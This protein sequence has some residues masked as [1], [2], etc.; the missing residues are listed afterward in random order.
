MNRVKITEAKN[1]LFVVQKYL[2][3]KGKYEF[4]RW[5]PISFSGLLREVCNSLNSLI[6]DQFAG[7]FFAVNAKSIVK[8]NDYF[9]RGAYTQY[10]LLNDSNE[11][12][13]RTLLVYIL[14]LKFA[15]MLRQNKLFEAPLNENIEHK[16][17]RKI[18]ATKNELEMRLKLSQTDYE[19]P[20]SEA[21]SV[22]HFNHIQIVNE[23][24]EKLAAD[25]EINII[26]TEIKANKNKNR[27]NDLDNE[28]RENIVGKEES[29]CVFKK[30]R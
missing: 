20:L 29:E 19:W 16:L 13:L 15:R 28:K 5:C 23:D 18:K 25:L 8:E 1:A 4:F 2:A 3:A 6:S 12:R 17:G 24:G 22:P 26:Q 14:A 10:A 27:Q 11:Q 7:I 9:S 30:F 21:I